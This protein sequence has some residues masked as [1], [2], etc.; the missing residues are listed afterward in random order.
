MLTIALD[1]LSITFKGWNDETREFIYR[2]ASHPETI[3][4]TPRFGYTDA[5]SDSFGVLQMWNF[6]RQE[7]GHHA[8]FSGSALRNLFE[9]DGISSKTLLEQALHAGARVTRLDMALDAQD[10]KI[11]ISDIVKALEKGQNKGAARSYSEV[12]SN[13]GGHTVYVGSRQS[14]KFIRIY[15]KGAETGQPDRDWVRFEIETKGDVSRALSTLLSTG[16][17]WANVFRGLALG[18]L[19]LPLC[20]SYNAFFPNGE[21]PIG[22]PKIERQS[23]RE[24]WIETQVIEAVCKHAI[25]HPD[26]KAVNRLMSALLMLAEQRQRNELAER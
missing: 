2:F 26:S 18:M 17:D 20:D 25:E 11:N 3:P 10:A 24:Q 21:V 5:T 4:A 19:T 14:E 15:H 9:R 13:D 12:R 23:D 1:W 8:Q 16:N 6:D 22:L 7:M